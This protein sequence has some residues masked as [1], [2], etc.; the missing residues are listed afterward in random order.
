MSSMK[1]FIWIIAFTFFCPLSHAQVLSE[2]ERARVVDELLDER[3]QTVLPPLMDKTGI[4]MWI[5]I[6]QEY[7]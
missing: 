4:D 1:T 2:E 5:L 6:S 7:K 3:F